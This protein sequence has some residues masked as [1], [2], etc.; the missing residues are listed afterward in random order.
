MNQYRTNLSFSP[1]GDLPPAIKNIMLINATVF[2]LQLNLSLNQV[3]VSNFALRP[4]EVIYSFRLWQ[5]FTYLFLHGDF[6][7]V[8][9]NMFVLWM[10]GSELERTWGTRRFL[11]YYL[12]TG[13][14]AGLFVLFLSDAS[15]IGASGAVYGIMIAY[16]LNYPDRL[17]YIYF[18]FPVKAKYF[19]GFLALVSFFSTIGPNVDGIAHAAHLGGMVVGFVYLKYWEYFYKLKSTFRGSMRKTRSA[20]N[21]FYTK[22]GEAKTEYYRRLVD[23]LL[24]KINRVGYINL[25]DDEKKKLEEG[26]KYLREHDEKRFN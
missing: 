18:M 2:I 9:F 10:F 12:L 24:D 15:T 7:H 22:G 21:L 5:L 20:P 4:L 25:T 17:I 19:M 1:F 26:S 6:W 8:F 11:I 3:L 23:E 13:I 16:A 14:G